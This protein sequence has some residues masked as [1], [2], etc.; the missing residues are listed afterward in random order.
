MKA[1]WKKLR[2]AGI[3]TALAAAIVMTGCG[4]GPG[5]D[6]DSSSGA[7]DSTDNSG[8][9]GDTTLTTPDMKDIDF[10]YGF[11]A[12]FVDWYETDNKTNKNSTWGGTFQD[13]DG[14]TKDFFKILADNGVNTVRLRV[15]VDP[16]N[17]VSN[18]VTTDTYPTGDNTTE[19]TIRMATGAKQAGLA[20]MLDIF[21]S[22]YWVDPGK[23]VIPYSWQ[24]ITTADEMADKI[25]EYTTE[26]L[27]AMKDAAGCG[28]PEF[29]QVGNEIN[30][31]LLMHTKYASSATAADSAVAG[32]ASSDTNSNYA[33]YLTAGCKAVR[34]VSSDIKVI[35]H[36][37]NA[38]D[39]Y[40]TTLFSAM[41]GNED[42]FDI[43]GLSYYPWESSHR[44]ISDLKENIE[45][46]KSKGKLAVVTET[47]MYWDSDDSCVT[48]LNCV[49]QHMVDPSTSAVY[50][51][52]TTATSGS[53]TY[54]TGS[55]ANQTAVFTHIIEETKDAGGSGVCAWGGE[56][57]GEWKYAFFDWDGKALDSIKVFSSVQGGVLTIAAAA[58]AAAV[59]TAALRTTRV[60]QRRRFRQPLC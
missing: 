24:S 21:Y 40:V 28:L 60:T 14:T 50:T 23:Q 20:V 39:S 1:L 16:T 48:D 26:V 25:T 53:T 7:T 52:L 6:D 55:V 54:V 29:V 4:S 41:S 49:Y 31:G 58:I 13:T 10:I 17:A 46:I 30:S 51:D 56:L 33:K 32:T 44:T 36:V 15:M 45:T 5:G 22:D 34:A 18:G 35:L 3:L 27:N 47:S 59:V 19:R 57:A 9:G 37:T 43:V 11:D 38:Y 2:A 8:S 12:S 42:C